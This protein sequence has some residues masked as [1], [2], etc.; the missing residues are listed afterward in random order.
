MIDTMYVTKDAVGNPLV[1]ESG[2]VYKKFNEQIELD[3]LVS[4][5]LIKS[6]V[7]DIKIIDAAVTNLVKKFQVTTN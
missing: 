7:V 6:P 2:R 3:Y 4:A 5:K 1:Y